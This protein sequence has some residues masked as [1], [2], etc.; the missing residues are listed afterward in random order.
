MSSLLKEQKSED[1][2]INFH[3]A[4]K[5]ESLFIEYPWYSNGDIDYN[6]LLNN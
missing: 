4:F 3:P 5:S 6:L 2:E 1:I